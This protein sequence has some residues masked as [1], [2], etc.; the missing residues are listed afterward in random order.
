MPEQKLSDG[1]LFRMEP[2]LATQAIILQARLIKLLGSAVDNLP[3]IMA[4]YGKNATDEAKEASNAAAISA[5]VSIFSKAEPKEVADIIATLCSSGS[6]K[7]K[8]ESGYDRV[9]FD[10]H[11]S[12]RQK[13][14]Y[15]IVAFVLRETFGDF[16]S[17]LPVSGAQKPKS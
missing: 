4:G 8:G 3:T 6:I 16:F 14:I 11:F 1:A 7:P 10:A 12:D 13:D 5:I 2:M 9:D 15:P 17:G